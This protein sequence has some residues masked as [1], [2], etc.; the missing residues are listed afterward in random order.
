[1]EALGIN[2]GYF[3]FQLLLCGVGILAF[4]LPILA[5][6]RLRDR[7]DMNDNTKLVWVLIIVFAPYIG[8]IAFFIMTGENNGK[9]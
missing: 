9:K 1:M 3:V 6:V 5:I 7:T 8:A 4:V 2:L